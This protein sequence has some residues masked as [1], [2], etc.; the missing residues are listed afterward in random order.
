MPHSLHATPPLQSISSPVPLPQA[1]ATSVNGPSA[2]MN[3]PGVQAYT[4]SYIQYMHTNALR[5]LARQP[6][7]FWPRHIGNI[8]HARVFAKRGIEATG[9]G[10]P[11]ALNEDFPV[12]IP[13]QGVD[14]GVKYV[15]TY[16]E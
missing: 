7:V 2:G 3:P 5:I 16:V 11:S 1:R 4:F 6:R 15:S 13:E 14:D 12:N 8:D 10:W 9:R